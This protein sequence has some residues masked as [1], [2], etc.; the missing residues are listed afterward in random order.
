MNGA[1]TVSP[2]AW[3]LILSLA[4]LWGGSYFLTGFVL[5]ELPPLTVAALRIGIAAVL[6][7][8]LRP[9]LGFDLPW[10]AAVWTPFL[11]MGLLNNAIPFSL[12]AWS[13][14]EI[15]SGLASILNA[16]TPMLTALVAHALTRNEKLTPVK[17]LGIAAG[18]LGVVV[19]IGGDVLVQTLSGSVLGQMACLGAALSYAFAAVFGRRFAAMGVKPMTI[20]AGQLTCGG[21]LLLP[22]ALWAEQP[23]TLAVVSAETWGAMFCI[24]ALSTA[25]AYIIYFRILALAGA[26]NSLLVTFLMPPVAIVLGAVFLG[27][28][29]A[30]SDFAGMALILAGLACIDGRLFHLSRLLS[31]ENVRR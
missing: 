30:G 9:V 10:T 28:R 12:I 2:F 5:L 3:A 25:L 17:V 29:L 23:W 15:A 8:L 11:V 19:L 21:L 27:E 13:Q 16:T 31:R 18:F 26:V 14:T 1:P 22:V 20:A 6:L 4:L 24:A 7:H